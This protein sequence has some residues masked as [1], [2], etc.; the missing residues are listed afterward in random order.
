[1]VCDNNV[2]HI[3]LPSTSAHVTREPC[4]FSVVATTRKHLHF[5]ALSQRALGALLLPLYPHRRLT[6]SNLEIGRR[7]VVEIF[8]MQPSVLR[9]GLA[10][11]K[12]AVDFTTHILPA[13]IPHS[14]ACY[15][16]CLVYFFS[17]CNK[18]PKTTQDGGGRD[19]QLPACNHRILF[20]TTSNATRRRSYRV[21]PVLCNGK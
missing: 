13:L 19:G 20:F 21:L 15:P 12:F 17:T 1:M 5:E 10:L 14:F 3:K 9:V 7:A 6:E 18:V 4:S 16:F 2:S 11:A 8:R